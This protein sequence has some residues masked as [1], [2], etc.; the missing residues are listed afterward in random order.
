MNLVYIGRLI[1]LKSLNLPERGVATVSAVLGAVPF[2][3]NGIMIV[4]LER[5]TLTPFKVLSNPGIDLAILCR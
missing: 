5:D 4:K 1:G 3:L 2:S